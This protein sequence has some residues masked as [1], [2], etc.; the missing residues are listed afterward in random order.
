M[1]PNHAFGGQ[2]LGHPATT[3]RLDRLVE[4]NRQT[5]AEIAEREQ[6][7]RNEAAYLKYVRR[8]FDAEGD[9]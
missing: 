9:R 5:D 3:H 2:S 6:R 7:E 8:I 1:N 4:A